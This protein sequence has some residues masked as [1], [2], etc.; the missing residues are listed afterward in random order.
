MLAGMNE[1]ATL[2]LDRIESVSDILKELKHFKGLTKL[3]LDISGISDDDSKQLA[4][5][6]HLTSLSLNSAPIP[7]TGLKDLATLSSL[8]R[9]QLEDTLIVN[10]GILASLPN[11]TALSRAPRQSRTPDWSVWENSKPQVACAE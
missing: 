6:H 8:N 1:L 11:L 3:S 10:A 4:E 9:L 5:L 2:N 7:D